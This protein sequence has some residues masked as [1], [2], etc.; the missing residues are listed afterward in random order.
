MRRRR[1]LP[2]LA[3]AVLTGGVLVAAASRG[4][5][6]AAADPLA[7]AI[8]A[9][10]APGHAWQPEPAAYGNHRTDGVP[11]RMPDGVVLRA[12]IDVPTDPTTGAAA[13]GPF[14]VLMTMTP[15]GKEVGQPAHNGVDTYLTDRG[16]ITVAVDVRGTGASGGT[17]TLFDPKQTSDGVQLVRWAAALP[18]SSGSV[19]LYGASYLGIDQLLTAGAVGPGSPLKAIFPIVSA[20]DIY[21]DT[22]FMGGIPDGTFDAVYLGG[23]LPIDNLLTPLASA[24][25][26]PADITT[27]LQNI[28]AHLADALNYNATFIAQSYLG[29]PNSYDSAYYRSRSPANVLAN[30]VR[31]GVP[32][33]LVGGEYDLFQRGEPLNYA[34]FQNA[35]AGRAVGA[36]MQSGQPVTGRYQLLDGPYTHLEASISAVPSFENLELEWFD[37]WLKGE[38]TGMGETPTPLHYYDLGTGSYANTTTYPLTGATPTTFYFGAGRSGSALS[39]NDGT[40]TTAAPTAA[41]GS[42]AVT[43][44]P[45]GTSICSRAQDQWAMGALSLLPH[46][47]GLAVPCIDDDR[48]SQ[49]GPT[50]LTYTTAPLSSARTV[51]GPISARIY[52]SATTRESEWV[53]NVEDVAPDG[54]STPLTEGALLGSFR[55]LDAARTWT[56]DGATLIP[57]HDFTK[58][59]QHAVVPGQVTAYDI[60]V[61]PTYATIAAG[62]RIRVTVSTTDFPHLMPTPGQLLNLLGGV[63]SVQR[64]AQ[65]ASSVTIPLI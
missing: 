34:A 10:A 56:V 54:A 39:T 48:P 46:M 5:V 49:V 40:L 27:Y 21:R 2:L 1:P 13:P 63:Y 24:F 58:A 38:D 12:E 22:A 25:A 64:T 43:W 4:P 20:N 50:A 15:Y 23:L 35:W 52:A 8:A 30:V 19:G 31:N 37:T 3:A 7:A 65:A 51:A 9:S 36:P 11:V 53:V 59:T 44:L 47:A 32:A 57:Y 17:F 33:Y 26:D 62:H 41:S 45:V 29:G 55:Q 18:H 60:E 6:G 16:Y 28:P 61:F 42:D 14:P